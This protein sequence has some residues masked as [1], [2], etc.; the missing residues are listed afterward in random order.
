MIHGNGLVF[1]I[2]VHF[3]LKTLLGQGQRQETEPSYY[4][5]MPLLQKSVFPLN[6]FSGG[7][8][9]LLHCY[10]CFFLQRCAFNWIVVGS[11]VYGN[12]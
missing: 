3:K 9:P 11:I 2:A 7:E 12:S 1:T 8:R 6:L 5:V 4:E 10:H